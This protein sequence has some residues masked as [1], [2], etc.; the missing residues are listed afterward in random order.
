MSCYVL[1]LSSYF[2]YI[3]SIRERVATLKEKYFP[4]SNQRA[5][6]FPVEWRSNLVLDGG[7]SERYLTLCA[8]CFV[9]RSQSPLLYLFP[10][11]FPAHALQLFP[12]LARHRPNSRGLK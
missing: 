7:K 3:F 9:F 1:Y 5:E 4:E 12:G 11:T 6:F 10:P 2:F 8:V